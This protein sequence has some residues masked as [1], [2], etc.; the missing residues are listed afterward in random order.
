M[1][2]HIRKISRTK[3]RLRLPAAALLLAAVLLIPALH[4]A[5]RTASPVDTITAA[6][7]FL[8]MPQ[9]DLDLL[10][11]SMRQDMLDYMEQRDSVY[12]KANIYMGLSWIET[13]KPDYMSVHLSDVSTLQI[14]LLQ[15][16]GKGL[17]VVMTLYTVDDGD[18]TADTTLKFF[19]NAMRPLPSSKF[20]RIPDPRDFY[21]IPKDAPV[22][23][24]DIEEALPFYTIA[25]TTDPATGDLTGR[26]TSANGLTIEQ[27]EKFRPYLRPELRW[28][29][30]GRR[31]QLQK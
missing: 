24:R 18:G 5:A 30:D 17:P 23:I 28:I 12:K 29:W 27:A 22:D 9:Q 2:A 16:G 6:K 1:I 20:I 14:K 15:P 31:M 19:D 3:G 8:R 7:A 11:L 21:I 13:L 4:A 26:L 10:S 25:L